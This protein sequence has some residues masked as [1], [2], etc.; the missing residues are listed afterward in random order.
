LPTA[1]PLSLQ[2]AARPN[3]V[4]VAQPN[5][6]MLD[7][8]GKSKHGDESSDYDVLVWGDGVCWDALCPPDQRLAVRGATGI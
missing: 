2:E 3:T 8:Q 5:G 1:R 4:V 7:L 6:Q